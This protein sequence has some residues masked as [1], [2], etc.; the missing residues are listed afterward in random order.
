MQA[1]VIT[2]LPT[3]NMLVARRLAFSQCSARCLATVAQEVTSKIVEGPLAIYESKVGNQQLIFDPYQKDIVNE[4]QR[5]Y[6]EVS[7]C[8]VAFV[9]SSCNLKLFPFSTN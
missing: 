4:L 2:I 7:A 5:C 1:T 6:E 9:S 3:G 8:I